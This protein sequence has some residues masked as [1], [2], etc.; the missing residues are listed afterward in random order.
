MASSVARQPVLTAASYSIIH[1]AAFAEFGARRTDIF[2]P[3]PKYQREKTRVSAADLIRYLRHEVVAHPELLPTDLKI[4]ERS[5]LG[6]AT[7]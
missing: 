7:I 1:F 3:V 4:T 2:G 5:I 6:A